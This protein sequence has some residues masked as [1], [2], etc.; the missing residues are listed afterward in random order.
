MSEQVTKGPWKF[1]YHPSGNDI[2]GGLAGYSVQSNEGIAYN[3]C[4]VANARLISAAPLLLE[5]LR[6]MDNLYGPVCGCSGD[7][8]DLCTACLSE[9]AIAA[10]T[11]PSEDGCAWCGTRQ[12]TDDSAPRDG[13]VAFC[14]EQCHDLW[15]R[16]GG[17]ESSCLR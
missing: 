1:S 15:S 14:G 16:F 13:G 17:G 3:I 7:P 6:R 11:E 5:A 9:R 10:A 12:G 4:R 8:G 2:Q